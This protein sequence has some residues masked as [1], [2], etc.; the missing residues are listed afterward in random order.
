MCHIIDISRYSDLTRGL[1]DWISLIFGYFFKLKDKSL[2]SFYQN[3]SLTI[4][5]YDF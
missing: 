2:N 3:L 1:D 5:D 4:P